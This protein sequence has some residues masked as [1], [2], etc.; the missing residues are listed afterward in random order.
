MVFDDDR[1]AVLV[2][3]LRASVVVLQVELVGFVGAAIV[4]VGNV[5]VIRDVLFGFRRFR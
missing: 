1:I 3:Q 2:I 5:I 4:D